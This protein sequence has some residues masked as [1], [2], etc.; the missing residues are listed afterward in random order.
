MLAGLQKTGERGDSEMNVYTNLLKEAQR[1]LHKGCNTMT[2]L[3]F[4]IKMLHLKSYNKMTN[5]AFNLMCDVLKEALPDVDFP[6]S[7]RD[8]KS[9]LSEVGLGYQTIHVCK[10]DCALFW[11]EHKDKTHCPECGLSRWKEKKL[12]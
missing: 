2:R 7:Y 12:K 4:I 1:E 11:E 5:R 6:R 10:Y 3:S 9:S 8:A